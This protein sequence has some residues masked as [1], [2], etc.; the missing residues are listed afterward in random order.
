MLRSKPRGSCSAGRLA[1]GQPQ[2]IFERIAGKRAEALDALVYATAARSAV[3][4]HLDHREAALRLTTPAAPVPQRPRLP[5]L[6]GW[7]D[8]KPHY[9]ALGRELLEELV[10][11]L[12]LN[13]M[14]RPRANR[15]EGGWQ[16]AA[17]RAIGRGAKTICAAGASSSRPAPHRR[18]CPVGSSRTGARC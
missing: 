5:D 18:R 9:D 11:K 12:S 3:N 8:S 1:R 4:L 15:C 6:H 16:Q 10:S 13:R 17:E 7:K 14:L 2:R